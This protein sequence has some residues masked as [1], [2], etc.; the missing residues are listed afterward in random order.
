[1]AKTYKMSVPCCN[2]VLMAS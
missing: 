1:M 2:S